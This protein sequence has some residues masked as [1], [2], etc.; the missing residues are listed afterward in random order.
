[1]SYADTLLAMSTGREVASFIGITLGVLAIVVLAVYLIK[2]YIIT[3][4]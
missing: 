3:K 1:M 2:K 4:I